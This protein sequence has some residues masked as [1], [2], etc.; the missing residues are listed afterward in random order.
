MYMLVFT[1]S[2]LHPLRLHMHHALMY[3]SALG[4]LLEGGSKCL[5]LDYCEFHSK[6]SNA[7]PSRVLG[8][9][10]TTPCWEPV[11]STPLEV[12]VVYFI[13]LQSK[14]VLRSKVEFL[15]VL[16]KFYSPK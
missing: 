15:Y 14:K 2:H 8:T 1:H 4:S 3:F 6:Y 13:I 7:V 10:H 12:E 9:S 11:I 5:F 16:K